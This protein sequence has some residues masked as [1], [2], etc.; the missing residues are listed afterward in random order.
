MHIRETK[1]SP[2]H[3]VAHTL[4]Y[5]GLIL[6]RMHTFHATR[7]CNVLLA[8]HSKMYL[9]FFLRVAS[10]QSRDRVISTYSVLAAEPFIYID[11]NFSIADRSLV[12][13]CLVMSFL[14][15]LFYLLFLY[16]EYIDMNRLQ[17]NYP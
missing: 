10:Y 16:N 9:R 11:Y 8:G 1:S 3:E 7:G 6:Q 15:P 4:R 12:F 5:P 2:I 14:Q 13:M 17:A